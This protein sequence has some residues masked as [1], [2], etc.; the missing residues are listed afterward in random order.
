MPKLKWWRVK[1]VAFNAVKS[2][3]V[4]RFF[5]LGLVSVADSDISEQALTTSNRLKKNKSIELGV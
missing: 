4:D 1:N 5:T 3:D 2:K